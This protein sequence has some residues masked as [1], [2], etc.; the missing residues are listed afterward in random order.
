MF[1]VTDKGE[2][3]QS[4]FVSPMVGP[5]YVLFLMLLASLIAGYFRYQ[6]APGQR[7][8]IFIT[9]GWALLNLFIIMGGLGVLLERRQ[10]RAAPR[11]YLAEPVSGLLRFGGAARQCRLLDISMKGARVEV[12]SEIAGEIDWESGGILEFAVGDETARI[13]VTI[14]RNH[15]TDKA[16]SLMFSECTAKHKRWIIAIGYG[17]SDNLE[18][19][20]ESIRGT[21]GIIGGLVNFLWLAIRHAGEHLLYLVKISGYFLATGVRSVMGYLARLTGMAG[22]NRVATTPASAPANVSHQANAVGST[23]PL[24]AFS[25]RSRS[26]PR[27]AAISAPRAAPRST[28]SDSS[29][30]RAARTRERARSWSL[31]CRPWR[32]WR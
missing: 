31:T 30:R 23:D 7:D 28:R 27:A 26:R 2:R 25:N 19:G 10:L 21:P 4:D 9:S 12:D 22:R 29:W 5:F 16:V 24:G 8:V 11:L 20:V 17:N 6:L 18:W 13:P 15:S 32:P 1:K 3:L 14:V